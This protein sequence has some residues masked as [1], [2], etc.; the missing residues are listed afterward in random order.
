M[1]ELRRPKTGQEKKDIP[2][3]AEKIINKTK[4]QESIGSITSSDI[5]AIQ[6]KYEAQIEQLRKENSNLK[7][8]ERLSINEEKV[9]S[10]IRSERLNQDTES[11]I[12]SRGK[13]K[14]EYNINQKYLGD[15][16]KNLIT[17]GMISKAEV[18]Y[19]AKIVTYKWSIIKN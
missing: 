9:L 14:R 19:S 5:S 18:K 10:A 2:L 6:A 7:K 1:R 12:I 11:P 15:S 3:E 4:K 13:F 17:K 16:I 8:G